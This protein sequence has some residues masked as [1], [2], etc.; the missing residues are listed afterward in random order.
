MN[1][2]TA[3]PIEFEWHSG[4]SIYACE[5]FMKNVGDEYGWLGGFD[6]SGT[7]RCLLPY[8]IINRTLIRMVRFR[9]E[10]IPLGG[11]IDG[12]EEKS[13]LNSVV[14]HFRSNGAHMIVPA[15]NNTIFRTCPDGAVA[16][17]YGTYV[18][19]LDQTE[20]NLWLNLHSKH[21]NVVRNAIK[22]GVEIKSGSE[23]TDVAYNLVRDTLKRTKLGFMKY[24]AFKRYIV[25]FGINIRIYV[26]YYK[27]SL[28]GCA[29]IP[30]SDYSA[31]YVYGGS[32][33][34]PL[35]G[36]I[37]LLHWEAIR[38]FRD[39]G[40]KR[41]DFVGVRINPKK[42]SK[43][44]GLMKFKQRFG[45]KLIFGYM[46]KYSI[47]KVRYKVYSIAIRLLRGGDIVDLERHKLNDVRMAEC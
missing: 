39:L 2:I 33:P 44:E 18:I 17:P 21:R 6:E 24:E 23:Y 16:A 30:F 40:V 34:A 41:Y 3:K 43:Q 19:N 26:A 7:L 45:G 31:Y 13:F 37:N 9:V 46:W 25:S 10:T 8:T 15:T 4:I 42:G 12:D 1:N 28:Q 35:T 38:Q 5:S 14:E 11:G 20:E 32:V 22:S 47:D 29:I 27:G 36:A